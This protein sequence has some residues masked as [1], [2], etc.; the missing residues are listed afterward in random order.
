MTAKREALLRLLE[1]LLG[2]LE[3]KLRYSLFL[4]F[5]LHVHTDR[6]LCQSLTSYG[7]TAREVSSNR[8]LL[9]YITCDV[10]H[11]TCLCVRLIHLVYGWIKDC[12]TDRARPRNP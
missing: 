6:Q 11:R 10:V 3:M 4:T 8:K 1:L 12:T 7:C 9:I 5:E 2:F